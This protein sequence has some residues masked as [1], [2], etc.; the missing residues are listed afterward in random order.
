MLS[1]NLLNLNRKALMMTQETATNE[2]LTSMLSGEISGPVRTVATLAV[3]FLFVTFMVSN[4]IAATS[5]DGVLASYL[6]EACGAVAACAIKF[7]TA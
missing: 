2:K 6:P 4:A 5:L 7:A 3:W 1:S